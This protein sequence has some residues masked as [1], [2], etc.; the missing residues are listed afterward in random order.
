MEEAVRVLL[1]AA[2]EGSVNVRSF[3]PDRPKGSEFVY[4]LRCASDVVAAVRRLALDGFYTIVNETIDVND[5]GVSGVALGGVLEFAPGD[6]PRCVEK[7]GTV[8]IAHAHGL[9]MLETVYGFRPELHYPPS[10]RV[11]FSVH[12]CRRGWRKGHTIIWE[13]E[14]EAR[15]QLTPNLRWPN[16]FSR[17]LGDKAFG[18][19]VADVLG[20]PVP[21]TTVV[22]RAV[23]PFRFGQ[24]TGTGEP[25]VRTCPVEPVPGLFTTHH[26]WIDPFRV[27]SEEDPDGRVIASVLCQEGVEPAWSGALA[28]GPDG[29]VL[30]EGVPGA[31]QSFMQGREPPQPLPQHVIEAVERLPRKVAN[32]LGPVRMEWVHDGN[33]A[34][35][36]QLHRATTPTAGRVI[37]PGTP[38]VVHRFEVSAGIE[39][40][41][42]LISVIQG[43]GEGVV[44]VGDVG[45]MS[46]MGDLLRRAR[47]PSRIEAREP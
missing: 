2:P 31:G 5:G 43:K 17:M 37:Y 6:T 3:H 45:V 19:L 11:E 25:W 10:T 21:A 44:L 4:G 42:D 9:Q 7:P 16:R 28:V 47:I 34:W 27:M 13:L 35:V 46:H 39:A 23:P 14:E 41:R 22:S 32:T 30:V 29:N 24:T 33:M 26:G 18:L 12:P 36:L 38:S 8:S 20:L 15:V 40:L 1:Q